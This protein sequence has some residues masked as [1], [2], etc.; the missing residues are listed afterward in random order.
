LAE[1]LIVSGPAVLFVSVIAQRKLPGPA[2]STL[3]T[4]KVESRL[5]SSSRDRSGRSRRR[6]GIVRSWPRL[7][8]RRFRKEPETLKVVS[9]NERVSIRTVATPRLTLTL[10]KTL[11]V[12]TAFCQEEVRPE[13]L[14]TL[15]NRARRAIPMALSEA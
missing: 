5:R 7:L 2:L 9:K 15:A 14:F 3:V 8:A 11:A 4:V 12:A 1:K 6:P 10:K 13:S